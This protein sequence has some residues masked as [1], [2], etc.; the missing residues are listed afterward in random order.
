MDDDFGAARAQDAGH[1]VDRLE[2]LDHRFAQIAAD[3]VVG[4]A[5][6]DVHPGR[7]DRGEALGIVGGRGDGLGQISPDFPFSDVEGGDV[8]DMIAAEV[9]MHDPGYG[10]VSGRVPV[11]LDALHQRRGAVSDA[12]QRDPDFCQREPPRR[13]PL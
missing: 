4:R 5:A 11:E 6:P 1:V 10:A 2:R 9:E 12:D 7:A 8:G 3:A 13:Q